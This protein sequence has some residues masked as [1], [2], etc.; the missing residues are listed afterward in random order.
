[1][2]LQAEKFELLKADPNAAVDPD[3]KLLVYSMAAAA[4]G[5]ESFDT[6]LG[7]FQNPDTMSEERVRLLQVQKTSLLR[8]YF[9]LN[10]S[11]NQDR[12][13]TNT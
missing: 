8:C 2:F 4:G 7:L 12:L 3:L 13:G 6:L 11:I 1:M 5:Q 10:R 9:D